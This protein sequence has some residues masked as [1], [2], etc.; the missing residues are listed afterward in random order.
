MK[1]RNIIYSIV[2]SFMR[3]DNPS[4]SLTGFFHRWLIDDSCREE[5]DSALEFQWERI[6]AIIDSANDREKSAAQYRMME[7][8]AKTSAKKGLYLHWQTVA[9]AVAMLVCLASYSVW[10][11]FQ[12]SDVEKTCYVTG[13]GSKGDF[14]LPDGSHVWMNANS[15]LEFSDDF[16]YGRERKVA[17][18][19]EAF[20]DVVK[21]RRPFIVSLGDDVN[22]R[23]HGTRFNVRNSDVFESVQVVLQS[24]SV[25]VGSGSG[26]R[27]MLA[28]GMCY[29]YNNSVGTYSINHVNTANFSNWTKPYVVFKDE[30][31]RNILTTLEHWYNTRITV[32]SGVDTTLS[33]S[34]TLKNEPMEDTFSLLQILTKYK[35]IVVDNNHVVISK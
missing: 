2:D 23:V 19:G 35:C 14:F 27:T 18:T 20:F 24:G 13:T 30:S 1:N 8:I 15:R 31:L 3:K 32:E 6:S 17:V 5:K 10:S 7:H 26:S 33:L 25:E 29:T 11:L 21:G 28:P 22:V 12:D 34:F 16:N 9:A 4:E